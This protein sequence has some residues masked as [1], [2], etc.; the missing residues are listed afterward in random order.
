M[1]SGTVVNCLC[2]NVIATA[3]VSKRNDA[4]NKSANCEYEVFLRFSDGTRITMVLVSLEEAL[5]PP[6][7]PKGYEEY[8]RLPMKRSVT[9][10]SVDNRE[11]Q[12]FDPPRESVDNREGQ[13]F[14]PPRMSL[15]HKFRHGLFSQNISKR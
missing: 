10:E 4:N 6:L 9:M 2:S 3:D 15:C 11:G 7:V 12:K 1:L 5:Q 13:K 14:D 8:V